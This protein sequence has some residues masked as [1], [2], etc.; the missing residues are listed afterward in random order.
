MPEDIARKYIFLNITEPDQTRQ[1]EFQISVKKNATNDYRRYQR[2]KLTQDYRKSKSKASTLTLHILPK[3]S[4]TL[5]A[6]PDAGNNDGHAHE[7]YHNARPGPCAV[8]AQGTDPDSTGL[9][10]LLPKKRKMACRSPDKT[11]HAKEGDHPFNVEVYDP[12]TILSASME[13][14]FDTCPTDGQQGYY[15]LINHCKLG[16]PLLVCPKPNSFSALIQF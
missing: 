6:T 8:L 9:R 13:D 10:K 3:D 1:K 7:P 4:V 14:P 15:F 11:R 5:T 2:M 16:V 12:S